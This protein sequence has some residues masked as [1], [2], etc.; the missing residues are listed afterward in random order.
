MYDQ[1]VLFILVQLNRS[2]KWE[3]TNEWRWWKIRS[4][5]FVTIG[6]S[7]EG[8]GDNDSDALRSS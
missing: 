5:A 1:N 8:M 7:D 6:K 4:L 2:K 3:V